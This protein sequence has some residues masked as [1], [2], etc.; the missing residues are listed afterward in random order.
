V[1]FTPDDGRSWVA[2][3]SRTFAEAQLTVDISD[4]LRPTGSN[5]RFEVSAGNGTLP[6]ISD[7]VQLD[8][9]PNRMF[10]VTP[11]HGEDPIAQIHPGEMM[12]ASG[13]M[14]GARSAVA[15]SHEFVW[16]ITD[17]G[18]TPRDLGSGRELLLRAE[19]LTVGTNT[20]ILSGPHPDI[21]DTISINL[22]SGD[23]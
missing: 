20:L 9:S 17:E 8:P 5:G 1:R 23:S 16:S 4:C 12:V 3:A 19:D 6:A 11:P 10:I 21:P 7:P 18:G 2:V 14:F 22:A 15:E 13:A